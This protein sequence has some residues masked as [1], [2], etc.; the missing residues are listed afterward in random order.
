MA[1]QSF[2]ID[3]KILM[4]VAP[5][6][7]RPAAISMAAQVQSRNVKRVIGLSRQR[8]DKKIPAARLIPVAMNKDQ[9][10]MVRLSPLTVVEL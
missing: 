1:R 9:G 5:F 7:R 8:R 3:E 10:V 2:K 4:P 6:R